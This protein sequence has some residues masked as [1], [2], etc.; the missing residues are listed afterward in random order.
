MKNIETMLFYKDNFAEEYVI[1][2]KEAVVLIDNIKDGATEFKI[3][4]DK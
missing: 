1:T 3:D 4:G 2:N